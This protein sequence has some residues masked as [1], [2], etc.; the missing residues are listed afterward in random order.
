M[1]YLKKIISQLVHRCFGRV[2]IPR[3]WFMANKLLMKDITTNFTDLEE[4][5][6][7]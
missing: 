7:I 2:S 6:P 1:W 5:Y 4:P 3:Q